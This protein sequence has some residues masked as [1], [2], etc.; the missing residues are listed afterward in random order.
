[1]ARGTGWR[2]TAAFIGMVAV[3]IGYIWAHKPLDPVNR[4]RDLALIFTLGG[5][6]L[7][8]LTAAI[9]VSAAGGLGRRLM[10]LAARAIRRIAPTGGNLS[11]PEKIA[12]EGLLGLGVLGWL[13]LLL[14]ML[15]WY[16]GAAF[17]ILLLLI[18]L[19]NLRPMLGWIGDMLTSLR[20]AWHSENGWTRFLMLV[21][22][23]LLLMALLFAV[24]PPTA[25]DAL[26]YHLVGPQRYLM[27]GSITAQTDN[28][29][30]GFTQ[31]AEILY[32]LA[33]G[34][35]GRET[36]AALL[37]FAFGILGLLAIGGLVRRLTDKA[38]AWLAIT[39]LVSALSIWLLFGW[40]YIDLAV[41]AY[42][43]AVLVAVVQWREGTLPPPPTE[44]ISP[45]NA[46]DHPHPPSPSPL[47]REGEQSHSNATYWLV[48]VG[49]FIGLAM[50]VKYTS[51]ALLLALGFYLLWHTPRQAIRSGFIIGLA[52]LVAF[53]PWAVKGILLYQNPVYPYFFN[54][55]NWD[56]G[57]ANTFSTAGM[58]FISSGQAWQLVVMPFAATILGVEKGD[59][60]SFTAGA[61]LLTAPFLLLFGWRWLDVRG[62]SLAR[63]CVLLSLPLLGFWIVMAAATGI[64]VQTRLMMM[65]MPLV[66]V[67]AALGFYSLSRAPRKPL[68]MRFM[69]RALIA[70]TLIFSLLDAVRA[71]VGA[72]I[73]P[74]LLAD[75]SAEDYRAE[76]L[77]VYSIAMNRLAE[78]P[79]GS[80]VRL[81]FEPRTYYCP[82]NVIC[83]GDI[84]FDHWA[85]P[86]QQGAAPDEVFQAW[87]AAGDDYLLVFNPGY[88][89]NVQD[90]RFKDENA[91]FPAALKQ[92]MT[93]I[94]TDDAGGYTLYGWKS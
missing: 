12:L 20:N 24:A 59:T 67:A 22:A 30:L 85:R 18:A 91:Q 11:R 42:G 27:V 64:G 78:L 36:A 73:V 75:V 58:G 16:K 10:L 61:W 87:K 45:T 94:W 38:T 83:L 5:A 68:D 17:W 54:G 84:L 65:G 31:G 81:M 33:I 66:A 37:H 50:G 6:A 63:D 39:L 44:E 9:I 7:D 46:D 70:L 15:G 25:F 41:L 4:S 69:T 72:K 76:N 55:L 57:R 53:M 26:N 60:Y 89:F 40:P 29:F 34:L 14:G 79:Q 88:D 43:A 2:L 23:L 1:M 35:F 82:S 62:R 49:V 92:W 86:L 74:Y 32:G 48:M 56:A 80:Q 3:F 47:S 52:A 13:T 8:V 90:P 77:G 21:T 51:G 19:V 28:H 71:T 93:P